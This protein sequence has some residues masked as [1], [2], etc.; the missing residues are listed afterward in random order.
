MPLFFI[1]LI[2]ANIALTLFYLAYRLGLRR[3]TFYTLNRIF[4]IFGILFSVIFPLISLNGFFSR[5]EQLA[6]TVTYYSPN[7][8]LLQQPAQPESLTI[9]GILEYAFWIGVT[10]MLIRFCI[11]LFSLL[12]IH[13]RTR[14]SLL[15]KEKVRLMHD[16]ISPFSFFRN[17]YIN[18]SL[19]NTAEIERIILH[20]K[21]HVKGWHTVDVL[22][23]EINTIFYWFNPGAWM[24]K[25]AIREN[26]EFIADRKILRSGTDAKAYQYNLIKTS[27]LPFAASIV[28]NFN[29]SHLGKRILMMNKQRSSDFH[30]LRYLF[31]LP[32]IAGIV[33]V[34]TSSKGQNNPSA[35]S[36]TTGQL[37]V[38]DSF[39]ISDVIHPLVNNPLLALIQPS[40]TS[41]D[42]IS[43]TY[44]VAETSKERDYDKHTKVDADKLKQN[45]T[46]TFTDT[47]PP[48]RK[49]PSTV[50][51]KVTFTPPKVMKD[52]MH[53]IKP[54]VKF[55]PPK[56][57]KDT[58]HLTIP[59]VY[60]IR[61]TGLPKVEYQHPHS[62]AKSKINITANKVEVLNL[63]E[64]VQYYI[65]G[66]SSDIS[67][68]K[69]LD[70]NNIGAISVIKDS[71]AK[72]STA[73]KKGNGVIKIYTKDYIKDNPSFS[74][75]DST[76]QH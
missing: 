26:L 37:N 34:V 43:F 47:V 30:L 24:M 56:V 55:T 63:P 13:L 35:K 7:W 70:P 9:W 45:V 12:R 17:I 28:N 29:F 57:V 21:V 73:T 71:T 25:T 22:V 18:P 46:L 52:T 48:D 51:P 14:D 19:Y 44:L 41:R 1:Y 20:E 65:N 39:T 27:N 58:A 38:A 4:L 61:D 66:K 8:H 16:N 74:E 49:Q 67:K 36:M 11:Q 10:V 32:V 40:D 64:N 69:S 5:H 15:N 33:L 42:S 62:K 60:V 3:L 54:K 23:G 76:H 53:L 75:E 50:K 2:K 68:I 72:S 59:K 31:L 6:G